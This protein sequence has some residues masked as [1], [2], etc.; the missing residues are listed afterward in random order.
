[1]NSIYPKSKDC[2]KNGRRNVMYNDR[3]QPLVGWMEWFDKEKR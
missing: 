1:L 2:M 3:H